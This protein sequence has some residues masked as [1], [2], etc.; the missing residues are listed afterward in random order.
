MMTTGLMVTIR[1]AD[2]RTPEEI[3]E[4]V[5]FV[6]SLFVLSYPSQAPMDA[7]VTLHHVLPD[8]DTVAEA[9]GDTSG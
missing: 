9:E 4:A 3:R 1:H 6:L 2:G 7:T 5:R 8:A